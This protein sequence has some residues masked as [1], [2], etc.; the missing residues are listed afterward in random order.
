MKLSF[1]ARPLLHPLHAILLA[2]PLVCFTGALLFDIAYLNTAEIQWT[3]FSQ[4]VITGALLFGGPVLVWALALF[5]LNRK[6]PLRVLALTYFG[7][8]A[9]MWL[10]G[11]INAFQHSRD[12]WSSVGPAGLILSIICTV[13]A[14]A[15][16]WLGHSSRRQGEFA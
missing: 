9:V 5:V 3:N 14:F 4:W 16:A 2:F 10:I 8:V 15:A 11:L 1:P 7:L 12:G 13:L 6:S